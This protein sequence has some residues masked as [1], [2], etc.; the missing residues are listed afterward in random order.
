[1]EAPAQR[2]RASRRTAWIPLA[3]LAL[4]GSALLLLDC[5]GNRPL[6][7]LVAP[8]TIQGAAYI[9]WQACLECHG[10]QHKKMEASLHG[11]V[12]GATTA[13]T[14]LQR[15]GCEAC[16][17]PGSLHVKDYTDP[18][19]IVRLGPQSLL[20]AGSQN[21]VCLQ[22]HGKG[23]RLFWQGSPHEIR[24]VSCT[25]CHSVHTPQ[26]QR[27]QLKAPTQLELCGRCHPVKTAMAYN[28][29]HMPVR[30]GKLQCA[31]CHNVHGTLTEKLIP[32]NSIN[33]NCYRCHADIRGPFLYEH[34]P[35]R[36]NCLNC[37]VAHGSNNVRLLRTRAP[38]LC[39]QCH[40]EQRH[41]STAFSNLADIKMIGRACL[42]CH[43]NIHGSNHPSGFAFTR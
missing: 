40:N 11:K 22:C 1:M 23:K 36:E 2:E 18:R 39:Q 24:D 7:E 31:D 21:A 43:V 8:P 29:A 30:E 16:H 17:G 10:E 20:P 42:G 28:W 35:V 14:E 34:P 33:E 13:R 26:A 32:E 41:P 5:T 27:A 37:H 15:Y 4:V 3:F 38:R 12:L 25:T 6:G 9:G 19:S